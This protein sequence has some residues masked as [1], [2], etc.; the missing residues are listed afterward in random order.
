MTVT[1]NSKGRKKTVSEHLVIWIS[2]LFRIFCQR[3]ICLGHDDIRISSLGF[4]E[5][6]GHHLLNYGI[7]IRAALC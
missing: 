7:G 5:L 2:D 3:R 6:F 4:F 1:S